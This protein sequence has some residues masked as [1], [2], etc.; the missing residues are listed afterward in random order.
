M[1]FSSLNL[2]IHS[3]NKSIMDNVEIEGQFDEFLGDT[4]VFKTVYNP[5]TDELISF[6]ITAKN[7]GVLRS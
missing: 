4:I 5:N 7:L 2:K 3:F 6:N 1:G